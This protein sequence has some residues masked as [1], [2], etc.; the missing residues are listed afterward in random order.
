MAARWGLRGKSIATLLL[1]CLLALIPAVLLG[2]KAVDDV[3][4]HFANAYAEN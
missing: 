3:R 4:R 2:W 1:A